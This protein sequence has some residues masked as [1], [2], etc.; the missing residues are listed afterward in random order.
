MDARFETPVL[1][2]LITVMRVNHHFKCGD[3][4][5][6]KSKFARDHRTCNAQ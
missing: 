1:E 4:T 6:H 3:G 2:G 5:Y